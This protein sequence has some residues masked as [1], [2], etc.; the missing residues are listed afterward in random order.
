MWFPHEDRIKRTQRRNDNFRG[1]DSRLSSHRDCFSTAAPNNR[2]KKILMFSKCFHIFGVGKFTTLIGPDVRRQPYS[3]VFTFR[4]L[5]ECG[6][7]RTSGPKIALLKASF[8]VF[9]LV[10]VKKSCVN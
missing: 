4:I 7:G 10:F 5:A 2:K 6:C 8:I 1:R 9:F 3:A